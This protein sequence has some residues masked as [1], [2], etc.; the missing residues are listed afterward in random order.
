MDSNRT[1]SARAHDD[2]DMIDGIISVEEAGRAGGNLARDVATQADLDAIDDP[3]GRE[4]AT[5]QDDID[6]D[7]AMPNQRPR[8]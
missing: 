2:S 8:D 7:Q 5:K 6:N 3:Q 4:R 1:D